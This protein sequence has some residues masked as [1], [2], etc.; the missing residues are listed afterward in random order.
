[1]KK[2]SKT[3]IAKNLGI[4]RPT[5][6]KKIKNGEKINLPNLDIESHKLCIFFSA[7]N[8]HI[9]PYDLE[10]I[11][12]TLQDFGFLNEDGVRFR[13]NYWELFIKE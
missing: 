8:S 13:S 3:Q 10:N 2:I 1:M 4:S 5:L 12:E 9:S 7:R 6:Y 11:L